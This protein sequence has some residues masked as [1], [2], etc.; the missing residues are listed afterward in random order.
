MAGLTRVAIVDDHPTTA[1]G[2][3]TL[4]AAAPDLIVVGTAGSLAEATELMSR[5][6]PDVMLVDIQLRGQLAGFDVARKA[7]EEGGPAVILFSS[8]DYPGFYAR[9][10]DLGARGFLP[11][12]ASLEEILAAIRSV[13]AG[14]L[15]FTPAAIRA[16]HQAPRP[17]SEGELQVIR[18]V[19]AGRSNDE[20]GAQLGLTEQSVESRLRRLFGRYDVLTRTE[21]AML[22]I[23]QGWIDLGA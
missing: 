1:T 3:A 14:G 15:A 23:R 22:A 13:G 20:I 2:L 11:K 8:F 21:L 12:T 7:V 19:A 18:L 9:A 16:V 5:E 6:R 17:P 4:L 10:L